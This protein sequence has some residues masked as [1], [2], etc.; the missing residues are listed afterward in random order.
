MSYCLFI[1]FIA[2]FSLPPFLPPSLP[3]LITL[4]MS[5]CPLS[6]VQLTVYA[7][8]SFFFVSFVHHPAFTTPP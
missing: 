4:L 3:L 6:S 8:S 2:F 5:L 7:A 1:P